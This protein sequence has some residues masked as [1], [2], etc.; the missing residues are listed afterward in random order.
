VD[1][2]GMTDSAFDPNSSSSSRNHCIEP[3]V[4]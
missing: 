4:H 3:G 1:F 2:R